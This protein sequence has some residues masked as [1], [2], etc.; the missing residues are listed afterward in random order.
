[1]RFNFHRQMRQLM[2]MRKFLAVEGGW[3]DVSCDD[4]NDRGVMPGSHLPY[5]EI[6]DMVPVRFDRFP[7]FSWQLLILRNIIEE[8]ATGL[9]NETP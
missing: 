7:N 1:M 4:R 9:M 2:E 8:D 6:C 5:V 3:P